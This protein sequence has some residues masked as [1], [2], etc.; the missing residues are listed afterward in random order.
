VS[1]VTIPWLAACAVLGIA[2]IAKLRRPAPTMGALRAARLPSSRSIVLALGAGE[3]ALATAA[4]LTGWAA[5]AVAVA[6]LHLG[7]AAFVASALRRGGM[8]QSCGCFGSPDVPAGP[9][10]VIVD[11][12]VVMIAAAAA[13]GDPGTVAELLREGTSGAVALGLVALATFEVL[14]IMTVL[15]RARLR[16]A[17]A[18]A[19]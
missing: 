5:F 17:A 16:A 8:V 13:L 1:A 4:V 19:W 3:V 12:A 9:I 15:P 6:A 18:T 7:F 10:H 14:V 2:G 11:L